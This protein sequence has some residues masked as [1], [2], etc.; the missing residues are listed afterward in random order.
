M[1]KRNHKMRW[2][3]IILICFVV[4]VC[5]FIAGAFVASKQT[6]FWIERA[7]EYKLKVDE[8]ASQYYEQFIIPSAYIE[9][10]EGG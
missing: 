10:E 1:V 4:G 2:H 3:E 6:D 9:F 7:H 5:S 8:I